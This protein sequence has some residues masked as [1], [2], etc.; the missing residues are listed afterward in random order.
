METVLAPA[1]AVTPLP[2]VAAAAKRKDLMDNIA[3]RLNSGAY[4]ASKNL[5]KNEKDLRDK[6]KFF[7]K[8]EVTGQLKE[9]MVPRLRLAKD[10]LVKIQELKGEEPMAVAAAP[11]VR[12]RPATA[13]APVAPATTAVTLAA[14]LNS[15]NRAR[16]N[17]TIKIPRATRFTKTAKTTTAS[18]KRVNKEIIQNEYFHQAMEEYLPLP[19]LHDP[20]TGR[21]YAPEESPMPEIERAYEMLKDIRVKMQRRANELRRKAKTANKRRTTAASRKKT[22]VTAVPPIAT[23]LPTVAAN[24]VVAN[25]KPTGLLPL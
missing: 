8:K 12:R 17:L 18:R 23:I 2:A 3:S 6:V 21:Q 19:V 9:Y 15:V 13:A 11:T 20:F 22:V 1:P 14:P 4:N 16:R 5:K 25:S 24:Q 10:L 7:E